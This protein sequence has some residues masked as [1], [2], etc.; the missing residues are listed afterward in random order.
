M[1]LTDH[2]NAVKWWDSF[3][4]LPFWKQLIIIVVVIVVG[5]GYLYLWFGPMRTLKQS[6]SRLINELSQAQ[7]EVTTLRDKKGELHR[8]NLHLKEL[9]DPIRKKAELIYPELETAAA[10]A[11]VAQDVQDVRSLATEDRY[12][13]L[14]PARRD[15]LVTSL[16][17]LLAQQT[18]PPRI[19]LL[20]QQGNSARMR[21]A[22][23]LKGMLTA[24]GFS[25]D[26]RPAMIFHEGV[27]P[28]VSVS[29]HPSNT[30]FVKQLVNLVGTIF[31]NRQFV[32]RQKDEAP[33]TE[34][35]IKI[36]G[37]PLFSEEGVVSFR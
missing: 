30:E 33:T 8:E 10:I 12:K 2:D 17:A 24:A 3:R 19:I 32:G 7:A 13:Q 35:T 20:V 15:R 28:D 29:L 14:S 26:L 6:N 23:D 27:P 34:V 16:K 9:L 1:S 31:I 25:I 36:I 18:N 5:A 11:K 21:V 4:R 37:D 22:N